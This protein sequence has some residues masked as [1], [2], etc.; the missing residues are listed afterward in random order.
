M[1]V[2]RKE[3][4]LLSTTLPQPAPPLTTVLIMTHTSNF[5]RPQDTPPFS[6]Q[7]HLVTAPP[8]G[9]HQHT[10]GRSSCLM[11]TKTWRLGRSPFPRATY[12]PHR[13]TCIHIHLLA[14]AAAA[15]LQAL[16]CRPLSFVRISVI[17]ES[18]CSFFSIT[19]LARSNSVLRAFS[20][21][22]LSLPAI[23]A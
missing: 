17:P 8:A 6:E 10:A 16:D 15:R 19:W 22:T 1:V 2:L 12:I 14:A 5:H 13:N 9:L 18:Q 7:Q 11:Q 23:S 21:S 3:V 20:I 4:L